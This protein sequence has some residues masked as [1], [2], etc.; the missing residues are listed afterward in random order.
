MVLSFGTARPATPF[1][2][3]AA[4]ARRTMPGPQSMRYGV[5]FTTMATDGPERSGSA[6]GFPVP[7]ITT[8][9]RDGDA[10]GVGVCAKSAELQHRKIAT[11]FT[12][13]DQADRQRA[14]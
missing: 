9:V 11:A 5:S 8:W 2:R 4:E 12:R 10:D 3:N 13:C 7:S 14:Y 6:E 1:F